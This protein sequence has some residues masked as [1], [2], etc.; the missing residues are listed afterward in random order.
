MLSRMKFEIEPLVAEI[1]NQLPESVWVSDSTT[2]FDPAIGGG[3]FVRAIEQ[4]LRDNGHNDANIRSRVFG[5]EE[6]E[7]HIRFAVNKYN[8][9]GQYVCK[10]YEK[11]F[12]LDDTMKFDVVIGNPPYQDKKGNENS[13]NSADLYAKF[14]IKNIEL[15]KNFIALVIP[16]AWTGPKNSNLKKVVFEDNQPII[17]N[18]HKDKWFDVFMNTCYFVTTKGRKGQTLLTDNYDNKVSVVLDSDFA[19][20]TDLSVLAIQNKINSF[21]K[22]GNLSKNW[23]RGH[24]HLNQIKSVS[25][26][27]EFIEAVGSKNAGLTIS[28]INPAVETTGAG[29]HKVVIPNMGSTDT[30]GN[31]KIA[32]SSQVGGHSVVFLTTRNTKES[33]NLKAYLESKLMRWVIKAV[34]ISTPNS[35]KVFSFVP[36]IDLS[37]LWS[38]EDLYQHFGLTQEEIDY[39]E[40]NGK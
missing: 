18:T 35:K 30:I 14:V 26:G 15:S 22:K 29:L 39:V 17:L 2:F 25:K 21:A 12:E 8:L 23:L 5:F 9:V 37:K 19:V 10:P 38:D 7:L 31:I 11:F 40:A 27:V 24:L 1:L 34:K 20:P 13:T 16:S 4:R 32:D 6:S 33:T 36:S 3:Q 28:V